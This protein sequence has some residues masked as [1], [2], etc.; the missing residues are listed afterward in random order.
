MH[1][2]L[3]GSLVNFA[4]GFAIS[5]LLVFAFAVPA[6]SQ[7]QATTGTI[8]GDISDANGAAVAG[9]TVEIKNLDTNLTKTLT[10]DEGGRFVV[11]A[12]P[13]GKYSVTVSKQ[14]FATAVAESLDLTV[15]QALNLPV[16]MK[17]SGVAERVTITATPT[18]DTI[19]TESSTTLSETA[20]ST[21]PILGRKF[22]DLLTL[23][24]GVSIV[25]GPDGDEINFAGQRGIFNNVSFDGGDYH[26]GFFGQQLGGQRA[27]I[28]V[29]LAG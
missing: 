29:P 8:Q 9:A 20:V 11:L 2:M 21:T 25:Q 4:K 3:F 14:G 28:D 6:F 13:P 19:K 17:V 15:G 24:P 26:N 22:E 18:V 5:L 7:S 27:A 1:K 12:L 16:A 10:T 23:T